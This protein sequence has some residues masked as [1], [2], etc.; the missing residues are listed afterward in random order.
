ME[1]VEK[2]GSGHEFIAKKLDKDLVEMKRIH[3]LCS[4]QD[5][6]LDS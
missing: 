4:S 6:K 3:T 1:Y 5:F 2:P